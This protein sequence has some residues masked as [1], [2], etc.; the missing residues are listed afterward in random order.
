VILDVTIRCGPRFHVLVED[1][2]IERERVLSS[3]DDLVETNQFIE[4]YWFPS[5]PDILCKLM[6]QVDLPLDREPR[7]RSIRARIQHDLTMLVGESILPAVARARPHL[8]P[9][10]L[11]LPSLLPPFRASTRVVTNREAFHYQL[12]YPR[13]NSMSLAVPIPAAAAAMRSVIA[14]VER[15][16]ARGRFPLSIAM[17][18]RFIGAS[19]A[20][21]SPAYGHAACDLELVAARG[22]PRLDDFYRSF[23][24]ALAEIA[25]ARPHWGKHIVSPERIRPLYPAMD[26]FLAH[27]E[28]LD[29]ERVFL[30]RF[31][32]RSVFQL[33]D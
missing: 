1:R 29:P 31:L 27:R 3:L 24:A 10:I 8:T 15:E 23:E 17:H 25:V 6:R 26:S 22:T 21:L 33:A 14:L 28:R 2:Y 19:A 4:L 32:E 5:R 11:K 30:N 12:S 9:F 13:C 20:L 16:R 7:S 18:A